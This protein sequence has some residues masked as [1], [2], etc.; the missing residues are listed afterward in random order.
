[1]DLPQQV[2]QK[3]HCSPN[4]ELSWRKQHIV[5]ALHA[6]AKANCAILG[7]EVWLILKDGDIY[8][9]LPLKNGTPGYYGWVIAR[10]DNEPW[11]SYVSRSE[12]ESVALI[13]GYPN[14]EEV[15]MPSGSEIYYNVVWC[16]ENE[17][18][19]IRG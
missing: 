4:G 19:R 8:G 5:E 15:A 9:V 16:D 7:G 13:A 14:E 6:I 11:A 17:F 12:S 10:L 18:E 1:M 2:I 3:A